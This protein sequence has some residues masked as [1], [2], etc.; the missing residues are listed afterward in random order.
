MIKV[1][2]LNI[3]LFFCIISNAQ[4]CPYFF[5]DDGKGNGDLKVEFFDENMSLINQLEGIN[6]YLLKDETNN[7]NLLYNNENLL[8][9]VKVVLHSYGHDFSDVKP[10][11]SFKKNLKGKEKNKLKILFMSNSCNKDDEVKIVF[12]K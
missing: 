3:F 9:K 12:E 5:L 7:Y 2:L 1:F 11:K 4:D 8:N 6:F 10:F